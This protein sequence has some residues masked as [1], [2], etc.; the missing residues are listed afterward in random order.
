MIISLVDFKI[1]IEIMIKREV[2]WRLCDTK[3]IVIGPGRESVD[4][5]NGRIK[6]QK[7]RRGQNGA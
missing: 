6:S 3:I 1:C 7:E 2:I 5:G 4:R